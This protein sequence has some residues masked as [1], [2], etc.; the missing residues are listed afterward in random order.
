MFHK[1][2]LFAICACAAALFSAPSFANDYILYVRPQKKLGSEFSTYWKAVKKDS[3]ISHK[4]ITDYPPHCSLTGFFPANKSEKTYIKA[5]N[6]A[7][8]SLGSARTIT[9]DG[10]VQ[11]N[12]TSRLDYV[13]LSS[14]Y[15]LAV[16]KAFMNNASVPMS[17]LKDPKTFTYHITLRDHTFQKNA[18]KKLK[19]IQRLEKKINLKAKASWSLFLYERDDNGDITPIKEFPL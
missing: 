13:K 12:V 9:I 2:S 19:K 1:G 10:L 6:D 5:V 3:S 11:G 14:S 8:K 16:T 15:L 7:I 17:F 4:A 18:D